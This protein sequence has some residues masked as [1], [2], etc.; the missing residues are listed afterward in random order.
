MLQKWLSYILVTL[1]AMQSV[2][3]IADVHQSYQ[4]GTQHLEFE[5]EHAPNQ[6]DKNTQLERQET[7]SIDNPNDCQHCCHCH[8]TASFV[9]AGSKGNI[10]MYQFGQK[11]P[12]YSI[13]YHSHLLF[14]D[15]RPPIV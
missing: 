2:S 9:L 4:S 5:H 11:S 7:S 1:I 13:A 6:I 3:A 12:E 15:L 10:D 14:P 8:G